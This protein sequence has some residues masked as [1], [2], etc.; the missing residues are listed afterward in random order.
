[1]RIAFFVLTTSTLLLA[2]PKEAAVSA[3][4]V[5]TSTN[6]GHNHRRVETSYS[7]ITQPSEQQQF[8]RLFFGKPSASN[9]DEPSSYDNDNDNDEPAPAPNGDEEQEEGLVTREMLQQDLMQDPQV[10]RKRRSSKNG[11]G[12]M[13]LDNRDQLPF[14][15]RIMTPD[16][17]THPETK[18]QEAKKNQIKN[19]SKKTTKREDASSS[20]ESMVYET[21]KKNDTSTL[22][23]CFKLD[24]STTSGDIIVVGDK[25]FQVQA[26]RCQ[27]KYAGGRRFVMVRKILEVKEVTRVKKEELLMQTYKLSS[28]SISDS[29]IIPSSPAAG[30]PPMLE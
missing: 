30:Q 21:S 20:L 25:E 17:Y 4:L 13:P 24:K 1:M 9:D 14:N 29:S 3:F 23:G 15:V 2:F 7:Y 28:S 27:Y 18:I 26:E 8:T 12:Y 22:L 16:P 5:P 6:H 10:K 11:Q 19:K